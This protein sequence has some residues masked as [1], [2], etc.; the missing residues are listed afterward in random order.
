MLVS[1][2]ESDK[3]GCGF[4]CSDTCKYQSYEIGCDLEDDDPPRIGNVDF[5]VWVLCEL[6]DFV[7]G[8]F[9]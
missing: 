1:S 7:F 5:C 9:R 6:S 4:C 3:D 2:R 8:Q